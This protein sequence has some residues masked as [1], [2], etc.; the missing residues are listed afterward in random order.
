MVVGSQFPRN[1]IPANTKGNLY[2]KAENTNQTLVFLT[3][4]EQLS[5]LS[6][7]RLTERLRLMQCHKFHPQS[8]PRTNQTFLDLIQIINSLIFHFISFFELF[9]PK[10][11][12]FLLI[13][14]KKTQHLFALQYLP[15]SQKLNVSSIFFSV[16]WRIIQHNIFITIVYKKVQANG[17]NKTLTIAQQQQQ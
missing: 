17:E 1:L 13:R 5:L 7:L 3:Q 16:R 11:F 12:S 14:A 2:D 8:Q 10:K 6:L 9:A 15:A 4:G